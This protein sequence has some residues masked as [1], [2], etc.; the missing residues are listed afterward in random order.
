MRAPALRR[1][2]FV[3]VHHREHRARAAVAPV[4]GVSNT[5]GLFQF[6]LRSAG[7]D[8]PSPHS[9][10]LSSV[11]SGVNRCSSH[12]SAR[13]TVAGSTRVA[14]RA[15]SHAAASAATMSSGGTIR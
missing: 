3:F 8:A 14:R 4:R 1:R 13:S 2:G 11:I 10:S 7:G 5:R 12:A 9:P 15:G 6:E